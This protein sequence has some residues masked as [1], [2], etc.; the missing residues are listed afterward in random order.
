MHKLKTKKT[1]KPPPEVL[2]VF[3]DIKRTRNVPEVNNFWKYLA[4]D[5]ALLARTWQ[6]VKAVSYTHLTLPTILRV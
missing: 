1:V 4:R 5:P 6:G 3:E 2:A